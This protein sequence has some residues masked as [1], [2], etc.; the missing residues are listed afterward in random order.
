MI[1]L[2]VD[3]VLMYNIIY[4]IMCLCMYMNYD[5]VVQKG[6]YLKVHTFSW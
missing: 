5:V 4:C 1:Y 3:D 6:K 2:C